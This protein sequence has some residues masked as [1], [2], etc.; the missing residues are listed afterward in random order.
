MILVYGG[1][2]SEFVYNVAGGILT[3]PKHLLVLTGVLKKLVYEVLETKFCQSG[4]FKVF[5]LWIFSSTTKPNIWPILQDRLSVQEN[6]D[7]DDDN[8]ARKSLCMVI[9]ALVRLRLAPF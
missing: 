4:H 8:D 1:Y 6:H 9:T 7:A 3:L 5:K 2:V